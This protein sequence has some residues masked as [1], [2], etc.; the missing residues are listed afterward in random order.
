MTGKLTAR[1]VEARSRIKGRYLDGDGLFLRVL[2]PGK[3]VYWT[4]RFRLKGVDREMSLG[5]HPDMSLA[6][7]RDRHIDLRKLVKDGVDPVGDR[8]TAKAVAKAGSAPSNAQ[9]FGKASDVYLDRQEK[10]GQLGKNPKHRQQWRSTLASLPGWFR[11][12]P[13]DQIGPQPVFD[14]LD[15][16]W[17]RTPETGSRLRGR[18]AAVLDSARAPDDARPNPAAWSDWLKKKL[19][20]PR[21]LGKIDHKTGG[22]VERGHHV[23]LPYASVP[24]IM[25]RLAGTG[26]AGAR[27]LRL[28]ILTASRTSEVLGMTFDEID[29]YKAVW[30]VPAS[31]MK[32]GEIHEV[33]LSDQALDIL[34]AQEA[35]RGENPHVFPGRPMRSMSNMSMAMVM[36]RLG[37]DATVH[38]FR[39]SFRTWA[40]EVANVEF[41]V[42]ELCL[43]HRIGSKVSRAY[44]RTKMTERRRPVMSAW[45]AFVCGSDASNVIELRRAGA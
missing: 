42:A 13:V 30:T 3:R 20:D 37:V 39:S 43:S 29:F 23:A 40:S 8:R 36:R 28:D 26:G 5:R 44:N 19:G 41:E 34:R 18:I 14:A 1:G 21:K 32:T 38:G 17:T 9:R 10:R 6:E 2:D 16:V 33:P 11:D 12:L 25:A 27:A 4:Y 31:R 22:R 45:A 7:A 35:L 15:P 24:A